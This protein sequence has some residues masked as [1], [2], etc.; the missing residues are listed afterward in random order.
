MDLQEEILKT[1]SITTPFSYSDLQTAFDSLQ[2]YDKLLFAI[3]YCAERGMSLES[4]TANLKSAGLHIAYI[5]LPQR[6]DAEP[7]E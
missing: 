1:I 7:H 5:T 2:S 4:F 3:E 6:T